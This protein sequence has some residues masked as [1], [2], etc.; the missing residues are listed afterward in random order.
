VRPLGHLLDDLL[1]IRLIVSR[2]TDAP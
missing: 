1:V 2:E